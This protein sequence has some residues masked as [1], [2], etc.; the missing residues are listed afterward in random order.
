MSGL[1]L[2]SIVIDSLE[3]MTRIAKEEGDVYLR[4]VCQRLNEH[5]GSARLQ[6]LV[7]DHEDSLALAGP[8]A[9][10]II[11][12]L[13]YMAVK[14]AKWIRRRSWVMVIS[15]YLRGAVTHSAFQK[16]FDIQGLPQLITSFL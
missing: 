3:H 11:A 16:V 5:D 13:E 8:K 10:S 14:D 6:S 12:T 9:A 15:P 1:P 7:S 2:Y 4:Q